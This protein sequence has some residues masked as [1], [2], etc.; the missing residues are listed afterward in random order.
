[1]CFVVQSSFKVR[2]PSGPGDDLG[3]KGLAM[4]FSGNGMEQREGRAPQGGLEESMTLTHGL[5]SGMLKG[6]C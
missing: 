1:M 2:K 3:E 5:K 4:T 6:C